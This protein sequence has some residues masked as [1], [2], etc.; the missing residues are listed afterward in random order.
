MIFFARLSRIIVLALAATL[1]A[2]GGAGDIDPQI[3]FLGLTDHGGIRLRL[4]FGPHD[5]FSQPVAVGDYA[6]WHSGMVSGTQPTAP[7]AEVKEIDGQLY[8]DITL[9]Y[10]TDRGV[11]GIATAGHTLTMVSGQPTNHMV[12][13]RWQLPALELLPCLRHSPIARRSGH[14]SPLPRVPVRA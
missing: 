13:G 5:G 8:A 12:V 4:T 2:C 14:D 11:F 6:V 9:D 1:A 10:T 3:E 7:R